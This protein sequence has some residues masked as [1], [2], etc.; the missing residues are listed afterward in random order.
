MSTPRFS[1]IIVNYNGGAFL[2][3][4]VDSLAAQTVQ[5]FELFVVDN[6]SDDGSADRLDV[7]A[8]AHVEILHET[9]NHG[10]ARGNNIAARKAAGEWL[11][12]LN[13]DAVASPA[14]L[15]E[16]ADGIARHPD[17]AM[18]ASLQRSLEDPDSLDGIGDCYLGFGIPWRGGFGRPAS[19]IPPEGTCFSPCGAGAIYRRDAFLAHNGFDED[20][21]CFGEDTDLAFRMRLAGETCVFLPAAEIS[22]AGGGVSGRASHFSLWHGARNR[23]WTYVQNMP[24]IAFWLTLPGHIGLTALILIRGTMTGR[25]VSTWKGLWAGL[26][27]IGPVWSKRRAVQARRTVPVSAVLKPM[28]WSLLRMLQRKGDVRPFRD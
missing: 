4:A 23:L 28:S 18:F 13:P 22:H 21:F 12:L 1:I 7:S 8:I 11:V 20:F 10:F 24:G 17:V 15:E 6:A 26:K 2:Q 5:D 3:G 19:E 25:F 9:D 14:W 27:G 16:I